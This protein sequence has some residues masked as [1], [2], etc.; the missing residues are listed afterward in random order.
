MYITLA[1]KPWVWI[2]MR[3]PIL[4]VGFYDRFTMGNTVKNIGLSKRSYV[5]A[6]D[7]SGYFARYAAA[8]FRP[9]GE[10][11]V[12]YVISADCDVKFTQKIRITHPILQFGKSHTRSGL[13][14]WCLHGRISTPYGNSV[15]WVPLQLI[16]WPFNSQSLPF[17]ASP[18][19]CMLDIT[20]IDRFS[21]NY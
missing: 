8:K 10:H 2:S 17:I 13:I 11:F 6:A 21:I 12:R 4:E 18:A 15:T 1:R 20:C 16:N 5:L 9:F 19:A 14:D 3:V 7:R